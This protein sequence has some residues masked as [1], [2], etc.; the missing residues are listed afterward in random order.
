MKVRLNKY[1]SECGVASRRKSDSLIADGRVSVNGN[2]IIELGAK[3]DP[4]ID[5]IFIDGEKLK[6]QKKVYFLLNKPKGVITS[7][8]D[9]KNRT[10][11]TELIKTREK[12]FP[13]GRLDFNT[14]GVLVLTNDG[15]FSNFL[16]HPKNGIERE[17]EVILDKPLE[18]E[19]KIKLLKSVYLDGRKSKF[20]QISF[21][22]RNNF[23]VVN[24]VTV[25]G[26]N[27]F[28]KRMFDSVGYRVRELS[29]IR[30]GEMTLKNLTKGSYR[31]ISIKEIKQLRKI[32]K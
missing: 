30:F 12:I 4:D 7:T 6:A 20:T 15:E 31:T 27:H 10:I 16:T 2:L 19:D 17:Y 1:L 23:T 9:E 32:N 14:T 3:V 22:K 13:V 8:S 21:P 25:E 29:R 11:V 24:V 5:Q 18:K 26:R 28:V